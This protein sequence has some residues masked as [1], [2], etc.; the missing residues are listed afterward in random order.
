VLKIRNNGRE[1]A[2]KY[3]VLLADGIASVDIVDV[4]A[5]ARCS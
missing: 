2:D 1:P 3:F 4:D 5:N